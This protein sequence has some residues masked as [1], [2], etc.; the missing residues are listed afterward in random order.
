MLD[1]WSFSKL[2]VF[3]LCKYRAKLQY[4]DRI[5]EPVRP[6]PPG[7]TEHANDRGSRIHTAAEFYVTKDCDLVPELTNF[8]TEFQDLKA[9]YK[10]GK[11]SIEGEWAMNNAWTPTAWNSEDAWLRL[12]LDAL[13]RI[14][15]N[16][17]VVVDYKTG[18]LKGN[19]I[20]HAEQAQLY[21]LV[22]FLRFPDIEEVHTE[23]WYLDQ[24]ELVSNSYTREQG[25]QFLSSFDERGRKVTNE[26]D[27]PP[28]P[29]VF[30]CRWC[31]YNAKRNGGPCTFGV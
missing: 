4:V 12:K 26:T 24:N 19:E 11:V 7:K 16:E 10:E 18:K 3:E 17:A 23:F 13:V 2:S 1:S 14:T 5:P 25:I 15:P 21:Q 31:P 30:S 28:N 6:L 22:T 20:K 27:F 29:N 8:A 9:K